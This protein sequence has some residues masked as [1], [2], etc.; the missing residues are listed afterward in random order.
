[1]KVDILDEDEPNSEV[2]DPLWIQVVVNDFGGADIMLDG[3]LDSR[4]TRFQRTYGIRYGEK[5]EIDEVGPLN[6]QLHFLALLVLRASRKEL[7]RK[8]MVLTLSDVVLFSATAS[9]N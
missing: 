4:L 8:I 5:V 6:E 2:L 3:I 1:M 9:F 7:D